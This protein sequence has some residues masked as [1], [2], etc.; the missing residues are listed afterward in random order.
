MAETEVNANKMK[1]GKTFTV[2]FYWIY[3]TNL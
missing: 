1:S 3:G 2:S